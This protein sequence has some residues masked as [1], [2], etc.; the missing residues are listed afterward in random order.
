MVFLPRR[1]RFAKLLSECPIRTSTA[2]ALVSILALS[3]CTPECVGEGCGEVFSG[4]LVG[5]L[6]GADQPEDGEVSPLD[7][8]YS[9]IGSREMGPDW[10]LA[11]VAQ[12]LLAGSPAEGTVRSYPIATN[13]NLTF[14][15]AEGVIEGENVL[16]E[17]GAAITPLTD[18]DGD[19][20]M[21]LVVG[22]ATLDASSTTRQD[23]AVYF[24][25][26]LGGGFT[27]R[28]LAEEARLRAVGEDVGGRLGS[29]VQACGDIDGD[30]LDDWAASATW[31]QSGAPL[32]GRIVL[33]QSSRL[34]DLP[35][36]VLVGALGPTW[37]GAHIGARAGHAIECRHD[38]N[39]D[40]I[41]DLLIGAPFADGVDETEAVGVVYRI[42]GGAEPVS[43]PL[44]SSAD[45]ILEDTESQAWF[46]WSIATGDI[47]G[48]GLI[49]VAVGAPGA[50]DGTGR[51]EIWDGAEFMDEQGDPRFTINGEIAGEGFGR[52]VTLS[53]INGD[54]YDDLVVGAPFLNPSGLDSEYDSGALYIYFGDDDYK[55]WR[56]TNSAT[57][58]TLTVSEPQQYLRTGDLVR[59]GD[60][61]EDGKMD[62]AILHRTEP[63]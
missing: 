40:G 16:D 37:V 9:L 12:H 52:S 56:R 25:S 46:G 63:P 44:F 43:G 8:A 51:V 39:G 4:A 23:G 59:T 53:D 34:A 24:L 54:G 19:G 61:D 50:T 47:N 26:G 1:T 13:E 22:A 49:E 36:Q 30:G 28:H 6:S 57:D 35:E 17:F 10:D 27:G 21:D 38:L 20:V 15:D 29:R 3:G 5:I 18:F 32:G 7:A 2:T 41:P 60:V 55:G 45:R 62:L 14:E 42:P 31:D 48:D 11:I 58:A 33:A